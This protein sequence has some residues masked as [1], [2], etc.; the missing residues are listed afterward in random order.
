MKQKLIL[1][2]LLLSTFISVMDTTIVNIAIPDLLNRFS[3]SLS[4]AGWVATGYNLAFAVVLVAASK[5]ADHLGR[6]K[7]FIFGLSLFV[8]V[9][10]AACFSSSIEMLI[11]LRVIQGLAAA[12]IVPVTMPIA[13]NLI[14]EERKGMLIGIWGAFSGL[15]ATA[16]PML[17]GIIIQKIN[18]QAIFFINIPLGLICLLLAVLFITESYDS[19][20]DH[21]IDFF[22]M[23]VLSSALFC[24]TFGFARVSDDGWT[25]LPV[26][27]L[28]ASSAV[29]FI[30]FFII[31]C[32][33]KS[34]MIPIQMLKVRTFA[35]SSLTLFMLGLGLTGG[36]L[37]ITLLLTNLMGKTELE[38][39]FIISSLALSSM[40]TSAL[41]GI[42]RSVWLPSI[43]MLG[44]TVSTYLYGF[45][46]YDS[47]IYFVVLLL[48][49]SGLALGFVIGPV[50]GTGI[51]HIA[52]EKTGMASGIM[53]MMRTVGQ[54]VG[55][56]I[57]TSLLTANMTIHTELAKKEAI[58]L[59]EQDSILDP[60]TKAEFINQLQ[61]SNNTN[62]FSQTK[63]TETI[64]RKESEVLNSVPKKEQKQKKQQLNIQ[65]NE[66]LLLQNKITTLYKEN[67]SFSFQSTCKTGGYILILGIIFA[68]FI[69]VKQ[70]K[71]EKPQKAVS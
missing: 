49:F 12:F 22:G 14:S 31:E 13:L 10:A 46:S 19:S 66:V 45:I 2:A 6:K 53:N 50:M 11:A 59:A 18:W 36:T 27:L 42:W 37:I 15:A 41:S 29:L 60:S 1:T 63:T 71:K 69:N 7:A 33:T 62:S 61:H 70:R 5:L 43:G 64:D 4:Q 3:C 48:S 30:L 23:L 57:L 17:G 28:F 56:A 55:I 24:L 35:F 68:I 26:M 52:Y 32:K 54:A 65:K 34:P 40:F 44:L 47:S 58:A 21:R 20:A 9:S 67:I 38:A 8:A 51:K 16:G 25:S 39:G